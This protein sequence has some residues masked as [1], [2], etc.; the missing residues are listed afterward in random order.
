MLD[1]RELGPNVYESRDVPMTLRGDMGYGKTKTTEREPQETAIPFL[2]W[3]GGK[4][5]LTSVDLPAL[6]TNLAGQYFEPFAGS[7]AIFFYLAPAKAVLSDTNDR[8][9][10]TYQAIKDDWQKVA[11]ELARHA[12]LHSK[13]YYY[14]VRE[15]ALRTPHTRAAQFIYLNR[16]C[17][18]GLYRVN[19]NGIFNVP[20]GTKTDVL[21]ETDDFDLIAKR[22]TNTEL[23]CSDFETQIS[24]AGEGDFIFADPP[25]T[26]RHNFNGFIKY[27]EKLFKWDDQIRLA[28]A[29]AAAKAR[30][31]QVV[32][33]N[34]DH[35]SVRALYQDDFELQSKSRFS[36]IAGSGDKRGQ[37]SELLII[38]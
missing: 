9:I 3:A 31:A 5:W 16:T 27:N 6:T 7:A 11:T 1:R 33:T 36:S 18:N 17:W 2:K 32:C 34:A 13:D 4:R 19:L 38:G 30:G 26:V 8:L 28:R 20:I 22:L 15:Q 37:F 12:R 14:R 10:E 25:Y 35:E 24:K 29:L 21:L 23:H